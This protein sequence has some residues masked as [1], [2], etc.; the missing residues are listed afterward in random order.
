MEKMTWKDVREKIGLTQAEMAERL[1]MSS[2][3]YCQK[4]NY[5]RKFAVN[6]AI[7][8]LRMADIDP[9]DVI[10]VKGD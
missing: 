10:L 1:N 8:V 9:E 6:E 4:E 7:A 2:Q 5:L 3:S